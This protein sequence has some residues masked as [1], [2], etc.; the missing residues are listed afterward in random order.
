MKRLCILSAL[1]LLTAACPDRLPAQRRLH[2][3]VLDKDRQPISHVTVQSAAMESPLETDDD[4]RFSADLTSDGSH[5]LIFSHV[6]YIPRTIR[7]GADADSVVVALVEQV[8][9][10]QGITV[11]AGRAIEKQTP[12]AFATV[13]RN[14]IQRDFDIGEVPALLE[15]TPNL[16][17]YSDAGGGL[18]YSYL[19]IRGFDARRTP[20]YINGIP[21]NDPEDQALYFV[22][23]PDFASSVD[24]IQIQRGVGSSLYG[25]AA[26]GGAI[27]MLTSPLSRERQFVGEFGYGGFLQ[28]GT[29][30]GLM[31]K[32]SV[33]YST[34]LLNSGWS[35]SGRWIQ[36]FSDG[37]RKKSWYDG[38]AY[39]LS[40]G[41]VDPKM[42]TT[43]NL[44]GGPMKTHA[45]WDG[46][47]RAAQKVDRRAN[48]Y[49]YDN[50]TDNFT[51]PHVELHNIYNLT[52]RLTLYNTLYYIRGSGYYEQLKTADDLYAYNLSDTS[53]TSDLVRRKWVIKEQQGLASQAAL[54]GDR[55]RS[56][57]GGS[58]YFFQ[59][60]HWGEVTWA[61]ALDPSLRDIHQPGRYYE[62][63]G[64][65]QNLA[66]YASHMQQVTDRLSLSAN[67]QVRYL[68]INVHQTSVGIYPRRIYGIHWLFL[69]PRLG[70]T[71][72]ISDQ[73][74]AFGGFSIA[75]HE[76][77][78]DMIDDTDD[79]SDHP[80]LEVLGEQDGLIIYGNPTVKAERVYDYELGFNYRSA[81][82]ALDA[83]L[84]WMEYQHEIVPDGGLTDD[85]FPTYGNADRSL[86]R[87]IETALAVTLR[88]DLKIEANYSFN[89]NWIKKYDQILYDWSTGQTS[90]VHRRDVAVPQ[91]PT[92]L[93]NLKLDYTYGSVAVIY[94]LR[95]VGRQFPYLD[96]R[97]ADRGGQRE[98]VSLAPYTVSSLK[99]IIKLGSVMDGGELALEGRVD[100]LL[101]QKFETFGYYASWDD[102]YLYWP[103]AERSWFARLR[104]TI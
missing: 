88:R 96:G 66:G 50:E 30:V 26:F 61:S 53:L 17:A 77:N 41:R 38:T 45:A 32:S 70:A 76:P 74:S 37:Y 36:Q 90:V 35:L 8:Y 27:N 23:L 104:L 81:R 75:S 48:P 5:P 91:F 73:L 6:G 3:Q 69:S 22:D 86:H 62:H 101:N 46:I 16:Y 14:E 2:G 82:L 52:D 33:A 43:L 44:Y 59:S 63:F 28:G 56:A 21:L 65:Y 11:T 83:N 98:D 42:I 78:D 87:G 39:Y 7:V 68:H 97:F 13:D 47:T 103:G 80:R 31:R 84:F 40:I 12:I 19:K 95:A 51:Q 10:M 79:P 25:E 71:Y 92:Y 72:A 57:L 99:G 94:C 49:D 4:G 85:G 58:Y 9:P 100:N 54:T 64:K 29:T 20:V 93:A 24:N 15:T 1:V 89:D 18:G 55:Y 60:E 67:L 102:Q 34:G